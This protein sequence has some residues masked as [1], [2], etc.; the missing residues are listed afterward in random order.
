MLPRLVPCCV[1]LFYCIR[2]SCRG[3]RQ[4]LPLWSGRTGPKCPAVVAH[5]TWSEHKQ[6][7]P[8]VSALS[9]QMQSG[10]LCKRF[11]I[12]PKCLHPSGQCLVQ[13]AEQICGGSARSME[14]SLLL[15]FLASRA[16]RSNTLRQD[17][18]VQLLG[19]HC[20]TCISLA[21]NRLCKLIFFWS[22]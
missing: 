17:C 16:M 2:S 12:L 22:S 19:G 13:E 10:R 11:C 14:C 3:W 21:P 4:V 20:L 8:K 5:R 15:S 18:H 9:A 1:L 6:P 7:L